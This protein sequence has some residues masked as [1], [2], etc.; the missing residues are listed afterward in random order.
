MLVDAN[1]SMTITTII[2]IEYAD[3]IFHRQPV[4]FLIRVVFVYM[5]QARLYTRKL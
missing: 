2:D 5:D 1:I 4:F 3:G